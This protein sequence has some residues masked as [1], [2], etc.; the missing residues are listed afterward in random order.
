MH[1]V[2]SSFKKKRDGLLLAKRRRALWRR[3]IF[4]ALTFAA[5]AAL[6]AA[7]WYLR[8]HS[9]GALQDAVPEQAEVV[10]PSFAPTI[11]DLPGDPIRIE[12]GGAAGGGADLRIAALPASLAPQGLSGPV[13][14]MSG[15]I[16]ETG[17]RLVA[18]V[19]STQQDFAF[20][21]S[22][23]SA[24][25]LPQAAPGA[26]PPDS[27]AQ[28]LADGEIAG[29]ALAAPDA[30]ASDDPDYMSMEWGDEENPD[31]LGPHPEFKRPAVEN[32]VSVIALNPEIS[33]APSF[34][35]VFVHVVGSADLSGFLGENGVNILDARLVQDALKSAFGFQSISPGSI[36]AMRQ[37]KVSAGGNQR[38]L[39]QVA[40]Y[41]PDR[42]LGALALSDQGRYD[43]AVDPWSNQDL[44][45]QA[46]VQKD[47]PPAQ[48]RL[49]DGIYSAGI[50]RGVPP[51][52][53]GEAIMY[54]SRNYDLSDLAG[55]EDRMTLIYSDRPRDGGDSAGR[56]LYA[57]I[58]QPKRRIR[59]F[60]FRASSAK[61]FGCLDE[62]DQT[63]T[64]E[65]VNEMVTPVSGGVMG[66][67]FGMR[68]H[69]ILKV[70]RPHQGVDWAA[71][72]GTPVRAAFEGT[73][74]GAADGGGYGNV[75]R[76]SH[77]GGR[78]TRY[79]HLRAFAKDLKAGA[80]VA[81][82]DV[83]GFVGTTGLSTGPHLHFELRVEGRAIDPIATETVNRSAEPESI[84]II[85]SKIIRIESGG[86]PLARNP[87]STA[88]GL[89]QFIHS[90]WLQVIKAHR[91]DLA[92][93]RSREE[94][95]AMKF[96][97]ALS[98]EMLTAFTRDNKAYLESKG[99]TI[100]PGNLYLA[101]F[102]GAGGA[103]QALSTADDTSLSSVFSAG[104]INANRSIM[105]GKTVGDLKNWAARKMQ[106]PGVASAPAAAPVVKTTTTVQQASPD[107][108]LFRA[109]LLELSASL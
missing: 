61:D 64:I 17:Q 51:S 36:V 73:V 52:I 77:S 94:L 45:K 46:A 69:P 62:H 95:L 66:S 56:V 6:G 19:P 85:V 27:A 54:L 31:L 97:P 81:A 22:Q 86:N 91:P 82:G 92:G 105:E 42:F 108:A 93:S 34:E 8:V 33:R 2:D 71:P 87:T 4:G 89:G 55:G 26:A 1:S 47:A 98:R 21:Q 15:R 68:L 79:A 72:M 74:T 35:D 109:G 58:E 13:K 78:E 20:F 16:I 40:L 48:F 90:T 59:C 104:A 63:D 99:G 11:I 3:L 76:L 80:H 37:L 107:F 88:E 101:H 50:R 57:A 29:D 75:V 25:V 28:P 30:R 5:A 10:V 44:F 106:G 84:A 24:A 38:K 23:R 9:L 103:H 83:I 18:S 12:L 43:A 53:V 32:N 65:T 14:I 67:R 70:N 39:V 102:L 100:T 7:F 60:V 41:L 96:D 49:L